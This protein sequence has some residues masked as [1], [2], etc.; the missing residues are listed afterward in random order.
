MVLI[1]EANV[2]RYDN[3][4]N[5]ALVTFRDL[6]L[7]YTLFYAFW[8]PHTVLPRGK[9]ATACA[10]WDGNQLCTMSAIQLF[11]TVCKLRPNIQSTV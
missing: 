10:V 9:Q 6:C 5:V 7:D 4:Y 11:I 8:L 1:E 2:V 3:N